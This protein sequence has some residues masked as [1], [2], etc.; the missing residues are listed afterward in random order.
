[1][2]AFNPFQEQPTYRS[3]EQIKRE[4]RLRKWLHP[5]TW[6]KLLPEER[7]AFEARLDWVRRGERTVE[8][9]SRARRQ[10]LQQ[11][12]SYDRQDMSSQRNI[13]QDFIQGIW[14][15][16]ESIGRSFNSGIVS[17]DEA[18]GESSINSS[19][20]SGWREVSPKER[21]VSIKDYNKFM[22]YYGNV[23]S[24]FHSLI[25][26]FL[27][28]ARRDVLVRSPISIAHI[29]SS[30]KISWSCLIMKDWKFKVV[31]VYVGR[32][33]VGT[34]ERIKNDVDNGIKNGMTIP[35]VYHFDSWS[36]ATC[37]PGV[38]IQWATLGSREWIS[39]RLWHWPCIPTIW[40]VW[41]DN[42]TIREFTNFINKEWGG[43]WYVA[44][45]PMNHQEYLE[46]CAKRHRQQR[47]YPRYMVTELQ[48][49]WLI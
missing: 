13:L 49:N 1:M 8:Y 41:L 21:N 20:Q 32:W 15:W 4:Q 45:E 22:E 12:L 35:W 31:K 37:E 28:T 17:P 46:A 24:E 23:P 43:F 30:N 44:G 19:W 16:I 7:K 26:D 25:R 18:R 11:E 6:V 47:S 38:P 48:R 9:V 5:E 42:Q 36:M 34:R 10:E 3:G 39:W 14:E 40:C 27:R 29:N 33:W 2:D